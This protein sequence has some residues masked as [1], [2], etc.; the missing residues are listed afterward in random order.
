MM[1]TM[2]KPIAVVCKISQNGDINPYK[3]RLKEAAGNART[4]Y[5]D[6]VD[7]VRYGRHIDTEV[8]I[9]ECVSQIDGESVYCVLKYMID[10]STWLLG[11][12]HTEMGIAI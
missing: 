1:V 11:D 10:D 8:I 4:C 2:N 5:V 7:K 6:R 3:F 12:L 9:Y